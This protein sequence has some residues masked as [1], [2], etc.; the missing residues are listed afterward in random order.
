MTYNNRK[1]LALQYEKQ[2]EDLILIQM[3]R[4]LFTE[5]NI[6]VIAIPVPSP[7]R[8][9]SVILK[10]NVAVIEVQVR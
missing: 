2:F 6:H 7:Q 5:F 4:D 8:Y 10:L 1:R 9:V 3:V